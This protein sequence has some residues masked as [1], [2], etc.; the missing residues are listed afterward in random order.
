MTQSFQA[1]HLNIRSEFAPAST[2]PDFTHASMREAILRTVA[3]G[4]VFDYPMTVI[5]IHRYLVGLPADLKS[6]RDL[7]A[8][9]GHS[10]QQLSLSGEY[11]CLS[12]REALEGVRRQRERISRQ[13]WPR[14]RHYGRLI[15]SL[16]FIRMVAVTGSLAVDNPEAQGD[17]DYL[18]ITAPG[19]VWLCRALAI[20]VVRWASLHGDRLCPNYV[21][22]ADHLESS[23]EDLYNAHE[24][25]QMVPLAG[26]QT[27]FKMRRI[28]HW[29]SEFL[30]NA[31]GV[32]AHTLSEPRRN[33]R[34]SLGRSAETP[35]SGRLGDR[36]EQWEMA[37][38]V[39]RFS[40]QAPA[41]EEAGFCADWCKGHFDRHAS[42]SLDAFYERLAVLGLDH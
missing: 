26:M 27:Y 10:N 23:Q 15:A 17:I 20:L 14:A 9:T 16:P 39:S 13:L 12:G 38:K 31:S 28:N 35:L 42:R 21:L 5:E 11:I 36:L 37:R 4:D 33:I 1:E 8:E 3:Y 32:P 29:T 19:R 6:I 22:S 30:P 25:A 34:A 24:L 7:L 2:Q 41:N 18:L 40:Q